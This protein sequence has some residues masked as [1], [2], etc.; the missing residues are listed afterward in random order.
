MISIGQYGFMTAISQEKIKSTYKVGVII[1][2]AT[3]EVLQGFL[4]RNHIDCPENLTE[5][6]KGKDYKQ[7][8]LSIL[9][10]ADIGV[11]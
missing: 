3:P 4:K 1:E 8:L 6:S 9:Q 5:L 7:A 2:K 11:L 10:K